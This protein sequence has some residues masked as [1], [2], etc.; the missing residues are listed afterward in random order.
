VAEK[1][2]ARLKADATTTKRIK[3]YA[4]H[5]GQKLFHDS[6]ARFR[7]LA[8]GRRWGKTLACVNETAHI[9]WQNPGTLT[10]WTAPSYSQARIA[11]DEFHKNL[12]G[13]I[14]RA[15]STTLTI[16]LIN[17]STVA[18]KSAEVP[19]NLRGVGLKF[20]VLDEAAR[21]R[22]Q[23]WHEV[24][25]PTLTD[26]ASR[27][28]FIS[29]PAGR[30]WF[31]DIFV[32][33]EDPQETDYESWRFPTSSNPFISKA[34]IEAARATCPDRVFAQEYEAKFL[35]G[36]ATVFRNVRAL[37]RGGLRNPDADDRCVMG[38]DLGKL[39]DYTVCAVIETRSMQLIGF[40]RFGSTDW[41]VQQR[42][43][44]DMARKFNAKVLI[45]S[46][47]LGDPVY[48]WLRAGGLRIMGY[49]FTT[50]SKRRLVENLILTFDRGAIRLPNIPELLNE[51][52]AFE[53]KI[54]PSGAVVY[55]APESAHDDCV[56]A[57]ALAVWQSTH[58]FTPRS[59]MLPGF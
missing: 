50:D 26:S 16:K 54:T 46:T 28:V 1:R 18:F 24:L 32:R 45:D 49:R 10:W 35:E 33:G 30:N 19:D 44:A 7:I 52:E 47:G 41:T 15:L 58:V 55:S 12:P 3:L 56:I 21:I 6:K 43:I 13:A 51:L 37:V 34:D 57:L 36:D 25:R 27:A 59:R 14:E 20:L 4:P 5:Q 42:R 11:F 9:A 23:A 29:T 8:C 31:Y 17:G 40:D 2:A 53:Q 48:D 22:P 38:V 39:R